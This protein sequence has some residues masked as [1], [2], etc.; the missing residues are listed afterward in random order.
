MHANTKLAG[1]MA[2]TT[3]VST[4]VCCCFLLRKYFEFV[5]FPSAI[6]ELIIIKCETN[7]T[8]YLL[9]IQECVHVIHVFNIKNYLKLAYFSNF[10]PLTDNG[11]S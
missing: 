7:S 11:Q 5:S 1:V 2:T 4:S 3:K 8:M 6:V 10:L 9:N